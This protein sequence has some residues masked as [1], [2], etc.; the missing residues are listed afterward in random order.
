MDMERFRG[1]VARLEQESAAAP[2]AYRAKVALLALLGFGVLAVFLSAVGLGLILLVGGALA[3]AFTGTTAMLLL[4]KFGK[5][6]FLLVVP[7]WYLVKSGAQALFV[8]LPPPEGR[9]LHRSEAPALFDALD[10]MRRRMKG[11]PFHHVLVVDDVNAGVVQ[12]P[13]FGLV[14]WPRNYLLL[15][16]PL[17]ESM[18]PQEALAVVA[19]EYGHL[20]G[21]HGHFSA[22]IYR[23]RH[24][25]GT[26]DAFAEHVQ[27]WLGKL[28]AP[29]VRSYAPYFNA[30]TFVLAR[31]DEY[32]A[33]AASA[34]L[35]G[36]DHAASALKRVNVI[37]PLHEDFMQATFRRIEHDPAPPQDLMQRW[38][39]H[40]AAGAH[41]DAG[42]WLG[43]SLDRHANAWDTHPTLRARLAALALTPEQQAL[44]PPD[45][46]GPSA[47]EAWLG[48]ALE[49]L[50]RELAGQWAE[51]VHAPWVERHVERRERRE[52]QRVLRE[53]PE[54]TREE[55]L[56]LLHLAL[57]L[58]PE[59]DH[60]AAL[61]A[62]NADHPAQ[63][64]GLFLEGVVRLDHRDGSGIAL[65]EQAIALDGDFTKAACN[66]A[67]GWLAQQGEH[68]AADAWSKRWDARDA[69][70]R[71]VAD[72]MNDVDAKKAV[73]LPADL[74]AQ[75]RERLLAALTPETL[76]F[77]KAI[78]VARRRIA[79]DERVTQLLVGVQLTFWGRRRSRGQEVV[80][81][82]LGLPWPDSV[83]VVAFEGP[84]APLRKKFEALEGARL[85]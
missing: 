79:A 59:V 8:R 45:R 42:T 17:I 11:P 4:A 14:G 52:R 60:R 40:A 82:V 85:H 74:D 65:L 13:A 21:S 78:H 71:R 69:F 77:V 72:E 35:V 62:F 75:A 56:D 63:A 46:V 41:A 66:H 38:A 47:A 55:Q 24:T 51:R 70:D 58:D 54:R 12:R 81:K 16:L 37:A 10:D 29:I 80:D 44:L 6:L 43:E 26:L 15:G 7:L 1:L 67:F 3:L 49:P 31:N 48:S 23:L 20:A 83:L 32:H 68:A 73:L 57:E 30:Y 76:K 39:A 18:P 19:H 84:A 33:D 61:A 34:Q 5:V 9:A 27:G 50:R 64:A 53:L 36:R 22:F 28:V 25:W 2:A